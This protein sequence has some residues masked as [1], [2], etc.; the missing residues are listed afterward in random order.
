M[1]A[2]HNEVR[3]DDIDQA[4]RIILNLERET[5]ILLKDEESSNGVK[6]KRYDRLSSKLRAIKYTEGLILKE[7]RA[8]FE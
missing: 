4:R 3:V 8:V 7:L 6:T 5:S 1:E 2:N